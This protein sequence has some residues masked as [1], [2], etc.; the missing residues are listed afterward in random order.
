M[1]KQEFEKLSAK[2]KKLF[3]DRYHIRRGISKLFGFG[4]T[5]IP[6]INEAYK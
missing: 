3:E 6:H 4:K 5:N 2:E 1:N